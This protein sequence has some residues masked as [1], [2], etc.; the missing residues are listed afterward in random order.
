MKPFKKK[1]WFC[2]NWMQLISVQLYQLTSEQHLCAVVT[3]MQDL[4]Y[5]IL[6]QNKASK[7]TWTD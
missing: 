6:L 2:H 3:W 7:G 4:C 5:V 1:N